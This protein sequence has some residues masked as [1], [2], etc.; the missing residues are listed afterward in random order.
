MHVDV[1]LQ[2]TVNKG[3]IDVNL[4]D[5]PFVSDGYSEEDT[6]SGWFNNGR[7]GF[8]IIFIGLLVESLGNK[9]GLIFINGP[10]GIF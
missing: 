2:E 3:I 9:A 1:L 6:D 7:K 5:G 4:A 10:V 8:T